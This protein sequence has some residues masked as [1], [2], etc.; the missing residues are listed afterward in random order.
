MQVKPI[1][2]ARQPAFIKVFETFEEIS[3]VL[4]LEDQFHDAEL[5]EL[6]HD[7]GTFEI[8]LLHESTYF[9]IKCSQAI[10]LPAMR[11]GSFMQM[12]LLSHILV[13]S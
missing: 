13:R 2:G 4:H 12:Q 11:F 7:D 1:E 10:F 5:M 9:T 6:K 3:M 8:G